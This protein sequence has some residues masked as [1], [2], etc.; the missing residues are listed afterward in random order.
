MSLLKT[1]R[2]LPLQATS[3]RPR[4]RSVGGGV[5][6]YR[7]T[8]EVL[9]AGRMSWLIAFIFVLLPF[10]AF[11]TVWLASFTGHYI[12]LRLWKEFLLLFLALGASYLL[13][14]DAA[15]RQKFLASRITQL[16]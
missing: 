8:K 11:L 10:H 4:L 6:S 15:L 13:V 3:H 16:I 5:P 14:K 7:V 1:S 12:L 9:L 2:V